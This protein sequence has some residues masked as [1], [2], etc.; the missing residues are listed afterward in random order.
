MVHSTEE[1]RLTVGYVSLELKKGLAQIDLEYSLADGWQWSCEG[2]KRSHLKAS[3]DSVKRRG[4]EH[5][6]RKADVQ[7][8]AQRGACKEAEKK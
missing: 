2:K 3:E 4:T 8:M 5:N 6:P 1:I 7:G